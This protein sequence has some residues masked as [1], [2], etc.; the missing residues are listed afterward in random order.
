MKRPRPGPRGI[1]AGEGR[2]VPRARSSSRTQTTSCS[3]TRTTARLTAE[4]NAN[5][6]IPIYPPRARWRAGSSRRWWSSCST[7]SARCRSASGAPA[8][9]SRTPRRPHRAGTDPG[10][11]SRTRSSRPAPPCAWHEAFVLQVALLQQRRLRAGAS[12]TRRAPGAL[13]GSV[14]TRRCRSELAPDQESRRRRGRARP[15]A[16]GP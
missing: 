5:L 4:A 9:A 13:L 2:G 6:P 10:R 1:F 12:A 3:M 14:S 15:E 8:P 11:T 16:T 7:A